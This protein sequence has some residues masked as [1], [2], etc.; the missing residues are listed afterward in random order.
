MKLPDPKKNQYQLNEAVLITINKNT[1]S[2]K[3]PTW[4]MLTKLV[5]STGLAQFFS[6]FDVNANQT[7]LRIK[8][9]EPYD[10]DYDIKVMQQGLTAEVGSGIG[11]L[12]IV[13]NIS[14]N[15]IVSTGTT[16]NIIGIGTT[17]WICCWTC[18]FCHC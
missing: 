3:S 8:P 18:T 4:L 17:G 1:T 13:E 2:S 16:T 11:T 15:K 7:Q 5:L 12:G 10:T 6:V 14:S 9:Y